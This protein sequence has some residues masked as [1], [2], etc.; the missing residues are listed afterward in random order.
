[1]SPFSFKRK[2]ITKY[3]SSSSLF[4]Y[5]GALQ[6]Y[7]KSI[8]DKKTNTQFDKLE[9]HLLYIVLTYS[10]LKLSLLKFC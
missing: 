8:C 3:Y 1:M 2:F 9:R 7:I 10:L 4:R 6:F 5:N